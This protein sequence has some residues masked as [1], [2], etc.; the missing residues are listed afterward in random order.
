MSREQDLQR[1][2][3][4]G[5]VAVVRFSSPEPLVE[6]VKA[7]ADGGVTVAEVTFTVPNALD[8]I[9]AAKKQLGDRVLLGA[10]TVLDPETA[11]AALLAGAEFIVAPSLN[12]D[13]IKVCRRYDKLVMPGA[14][15]PTEVLTAWEAGADIVK[16]FPAEVVGPP[17]FKALRG[18]LPQVKLMPTGGVDLNTAPEFLKAGAVCLGVGSQMVEPKAVAA[19]DFARI[20]QLAKQYAE[21]VKQYRKTS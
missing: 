17:F 15:T 10:G 11:R 3:E 12:L 6:V 21:V 16:V 14:F 18:P 20:T 9:R 1:V 4:C 5:I 2:T 13:V 19:G 8:V 7:L